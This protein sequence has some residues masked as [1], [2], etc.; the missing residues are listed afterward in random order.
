MVN[1]IISLGQKALHTHST[2]FLRFLAD[3]GPNPNTG[4]NPYCHFSI[5]CKIILITTT[6]AHWNSI[7]IHIPLL[8]TIMVH[9][10]NDTGELM[11]LGYYVLSDTRQ[12]RL[13][14]G[15]GAG[16]GLHLY[17]Y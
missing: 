5:F 15:I 4:T 16:I 13:L 6:H 3:A 9:G 7:L 17:R 10:E 1:V 12:Y 11:V 14:S 2:W 8:L